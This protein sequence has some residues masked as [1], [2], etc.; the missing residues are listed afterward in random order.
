MLPFGRSGG[1][2]RLRAEDSLLSDQ[3]KW[4]ILF[5]C[6]CLCAGQIGQLRA[7]DCGEDKERDD[8]RRGNYNP[9]MTGPSEV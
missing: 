1:K 8:Q 2:L 7:S 5:P 4:E 6:I 9:Q 3:N